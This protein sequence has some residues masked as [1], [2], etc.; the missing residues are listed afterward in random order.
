MMFE[1]EKQEW[2]LFKERKLNVRVFKV[3][4]T[5]EVHASIIGKGTY[6][7]HGLEKWSTIAEAIEGINK[8]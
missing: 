4:S 1:E 3:N 7:A 6:T 8:K 2:L 5:Y